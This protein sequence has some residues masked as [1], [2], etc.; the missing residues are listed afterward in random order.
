MRGLVFP[1]SAV[2]TAAV[3]AFVVP[4][5]LIEPYLGSCLSGFH[6]SS[7]ESAAAEQVWSGGFAFSFAVLFLLGLW[8]GFQVIGALA[9]LIEKGYLGDLSMISLIGL[10]LVGIAAVFGTIGDTEESYSAWVAGVPLLWLLVPVA[11]YR[12]VLR[13]QAESGPGHDLRRTQ[14]HRRPG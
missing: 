12:W 5:T 11:A 7:S 6:P 9:R 1:V 4:L 3:L 2:I 10:A 8:L 14:R 13:K